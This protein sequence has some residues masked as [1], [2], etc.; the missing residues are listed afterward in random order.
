MGWRLTRSCACGFTDR[1]PVKEIERLR[2]APPAANLTAVPLQEGLTPL[3]S[4]SSATLD[5]ELRFDWSHTTAGVVPT[6]V[7]HLQVGVAVLVGNNTSHSGHSSNPASPSSGSGTGEQQGEGDGGEAGVLVEQTLITLSLGTATRFDNASRTT[8][9]A[10]EL[11]VDTRQSRAGDKAGVYTP[12]PVALKR[13]D[14]ALTL[15][16]LVDRSIIEAFAMGGRG[17]MT[18]RVYPRQFN[19][20]LGV[21]LIYH[22]PKG[23]DGGMEEVEGEGGEVVEAPL[24][25]VTA[26]EME[27]G[28]VH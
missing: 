21:A 20:S 12:T 27:S 13:N 3:I 15:R 7:P 11:A 26:Y 24:V 5:L 18:R 8:E 2:V 22:V 4:V 9:P 25:T 17:A 6:T 19:S 1:Y 14:T 16:V 10:V 23:G 28:Y